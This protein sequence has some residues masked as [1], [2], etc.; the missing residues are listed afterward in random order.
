MPTSTDLTELKIY[1]ATT[2]AIAEAAISGG[3]IDPNSIVVTDEFDP[4]VTSIGNA[5]G[6]I[7]LGSGLAIS[8][9]VLTNTGVF[10]VKDSSNVSLV[11]N[12]IATLPGVYS[13][14]IYIHGGADD[15]THIFVTLMTNFATAFDLPSFIAYI[16]T[17]NASSRIPASGTII[18]NRTL[19]TNNCR[20]MAAIGPGT[21]SSTIT[22]VYHDTGDT[23]VVTMQLAQG[24]GNLD[25]NNIFDTVIK[26]I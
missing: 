20:A 26:V 23:G 1:H 4:A 19:A 2:N 11:T 8:S 10:D 6:N 3:Q 16:N 25:V 24:T 7:S 12:H 9:N 17:L 14:H 18:Y 5:T 21:S 22:A 13:H 15:E